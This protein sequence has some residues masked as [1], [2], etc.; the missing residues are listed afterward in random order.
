MARGESPFQGRYTV[1]IADFSGIERAGAAWGDA[2]RGIGEQIEKYGLKKKEQQAKRGR[3]KNAVNLLDDL[4]KENPE[5]ADK[6]AI[7]R[8]QLLDEDIPLDERDALRQGLLDTISISGQMRNSNLTRQ[9]AE[10]TLKSNIKIAEHQARN[11]EIGNLLNEFDLE[12]AP[13]KQKLQLEQLKDL[14]R[15]GEVEANVAEATEETEIK[16]SEAALDQTRAQTERV[17]GSEARDKEMHPVNIRKAE[18]VINYY[19]RRQG[20]GADKD[21]EGRIKEVD[22]QI[23]SI[24]GGPAFVNVEG[25]PLTMEKLIEDIDPI[26]GEI[27]WSEDI[28]KYGETEGARLQNLISEKIS[29]VRSSPMKVVLQDGSTKEITLGE[30]MALKEEYEA[31]KKEKAEKEEAERDAEQKSRE[32][33]GRP[34]KWPTNPG[35]KF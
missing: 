6:Y 16:R 31:R 28:N 12:A 9:L 30:W 19:N 14:V 11:L 2:F 7:K 25:I 13:E 26:S 10:G 33:F 20:V 32:S 5:H 23:K 35:M 15:V 34:Q 4:E 29:L 8:E 1:P 24:M 3:I 22:S 17:L 27:K 21:I 18:A